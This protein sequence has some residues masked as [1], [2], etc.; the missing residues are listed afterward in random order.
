MIKLSRFL[1]AVVFSAATFLAG[2]AKIGVQHQMVLGNPSNAITDASNHTN[3]LI[4]RDQYALDYND[5]RGVPN[6]VS[7]NLTI[8]DVGGSGRSRDFFVDPDM[9]STFY[10]VLTTD[11]EGSGYDRGHMCPSGDRTVTRA[12][13]NVT[14]Y[15]SNMVPQAPDNNRGVWANFESYC[16]TL[17]A[18]GNEVLIVT[19]PGGFAGSTVPSGAAEIP[20]FVWKVVTVVPVGSAPVLERIDSNTRVIAIKIPNIAGILNDPWQNYVTS[21]A[22]IEADTGLQFFTALPSAVAHALRV[23]VDGQAQP[24]APFIIDHPASQVAALGSSVTFTVNAGGNAPL[25]YQWMRNDQEIPGATTPSLTLNNITAADLGGYYVEVSNAAGSAVSNA[26][27]LIISGIPPSIT[28]QPATQIV[29]AGSSVT[30][31]VGATGSPL[32][33]YQWRVDGAVIPG[34]TSAALSI[35]NAQEDATGDYDV[36][37]SNSVGSVTSAIAEVTVVPAAPSIATQPSSRTATAGGNAS[38]TVSASGT[39][40]LSYQWRRGGTPLA[41]DAVIS[42]ANTATLTFTNLDASYAGTYDVVVTNPVGQ[43]TSNPAT[44]TVSAATVYWNFQTATPTSGV[45]ADV[46]AGALSSGNSF[47]A[48]TLLSTTSASSGYSGSSGANNAGV[49]ART[50]A[51]NQGANG[52]AYFEFSLTPASG[53]KLVITGLTFGARSTGTGPQA[54][55]IFTS[56]DNYTTPVATG[57]LL[58]NSSWRLISPTLNAITGLTGEP[59][60]VRI[61]GHSG[62]GNASSTTVNWRI[63]DLNVTLAT[64]ASTGAVAPAIVETTPAAATTQ[65]AINAPIRVTFNQPVTVGSGWFTLQSSLHGP[66]AAT[67]TGGPVTYTLTPPANFS[68]SDVISVRIN[69]G[70]VT[71]NDTGTLTLP[72]SYQWSFTTAAAVAPTVTAQPAPVTVADGGSATFTVAATG[73]APLGYQWRRNGVPISGN[74][75][76]NTATLV[77]SPAGFGSEGSY[78]VVVSNPAGSVTSQSAGLIVTAVAPSITTQPLPQLVTAGGSASF[79]VAATG[80]APLSYQWR[81]NGVPLANDGRIAG[82]Q[83]AT[84]SVTAISAADVGTYDVVVSNTA[85]AVPSNGVALGVTTAALGSVAWNFT[86][87]APSSALPDHVSGGTVTQNNNNGTTALLTAQSV[88]SG[89]TGASGGNN[90]GLAARIG[91]LN[92]AAGGSGYFE[93]SLA[94][95]AGRQ[96]VLTGLNFGARSTGTGPRAYTIDASVDGTNFFPVATGT[97]S[98]DSVWRRITPALSGVRSAPGGSLTVRIYG[99]GGSGS[100]SANT[101]NWRIDDLAATIGTELLPA[102]TASAPANGATGVGRAASVTV[103]FNQPVSAPA[104]AF[105]VTSAQLGTVATLVGGGPDTYVLTPT[106]AFG[107][108]DTVTVTVDGSKVT[109][110]SGT[111][112]MTGNAS[113]SFTTEA[114]VPPSI[115]QPPQSQTV[116]AFTPATFTVGAIGTGPF[117]YQWRFQGAP[118]TGNASAQTAALTL[119]SVTTADAGDYDCVVTGYAGSVTSAPATLTVNKAAATVTLGNLTQTY[120]GSARAVTVTTAPAGL[121]TT[122]TY[123]GSTVAPTAAG[124][125]PV[126]AEIVDANYQGSATGT[127]VVSKAAATITLA[128]LRHTYDGTPKAA[129]AVTTPEGL[130][131]VLTYDGSPTPPTLPG[132]YSVEATLDNANYSGAVIGTLEIGVTALVNRGLS[133]NGGIDGSIQ[134]RLPEAS[135]LNGNGWISGDLLVPGTPELRANGNPTYA[136]VQ[137]AAGAANPTD[138]RVTLNGGSVL[139]YLVRRVNAIA[140]P[141]AT[142][143]QAPAGTRSVNVNSAN[144]AIG[145]WATVRDLTLNGGAG[146]VTVPPGAYGSL[147]ANGSSRLVLGVAGA[148]E[149]AV[150]HLQGLTLNGASRLDVLGPVIIHLAN[151][152][153]LN[154]SAGDAAHPDWLTLRLARGGLT[155][156]GS[157]QFNGRVEAPAGTVTISGQATLRGS[158]AADRLV[159]NGNGALEQP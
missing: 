50:G 34:A 114:A 89:Y 65:V 119:A 3:Y 107:Y 110:A 128:D 122:V 74:A 18:Q 1:L 121:T 146:A 129:R 87:A 42:G 31:S 100:A 152:A 140:L 32:L 135:T 25:S 14:F 148:T 137:D 61:Y 15:M 156:N 29:P 136:G 67:V 132:R 101:A 26:A 10:T 147:T 49:A 85:G 68:Y 115:V 143:V 22:Q 16:R 133:L 48:T 36:V 17:A 159:V 141:E 94:A 116:T 46:T 51:L 105:T 47:G 96:L 102:V 69:A 131:V 104:H 117:S 84:L 58:N 12:D 103:T 134:V 11:Y 86:T 91:A 97:L 55:S 66:L 37:V 88:S 130:T 127:L 125:Y 27:E 90:A 59:I 72:A 83:S 54:Y 7:W 2:Y 113:F 13:N 62:S 73:T 45:P 38:F 112:A 80:S 154:S 6:W 9:P 158:V 60:T 41:N 33:T 19:G 56:F 126:M 150:Y 35:P 4:Q 99:H 124:S 75:T 144:P 23:K 77:I 30:L 82:A 106:A 92:R 145:D 98:S 79:T 138:Y 123:N 155:L 118:I 24:G 40:P 109:D 76:A 28:T 139:R 21:A 8:E 81:R 53:K 142:V 63:D 64:V 43:T 149:P 93:F 57:A 20:G 151:G 39:A 44:L 5:V 120:T 70:T 153:S 95:A 111:L 108:S 52:S 78:D 157:A 71:E